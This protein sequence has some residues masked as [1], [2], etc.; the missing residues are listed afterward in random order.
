MKWSVI[1]L[2]H[3]VAARFNIGKIGEDSLVTAPICRRSKLLRAPESSDDVLI[4]NSTFNLLKVI[5]TKT[6]ALQ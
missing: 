3:L 4:L 2:G 5:S 6:G 1:V